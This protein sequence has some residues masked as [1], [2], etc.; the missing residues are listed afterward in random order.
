MITGDLPLTGM[1]AAL[2]IAPA[3]SE[4]LNATS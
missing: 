4:T 3:A 1:N 2:T